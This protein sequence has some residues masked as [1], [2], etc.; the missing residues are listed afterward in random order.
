MGDY[1]LELARTG[2]RDFLRDNRANDFFADDMVWDFSGFRGW[3][4]DTEYHGPHGFD[5]QMAR[6]TAPFD[7]WAMEITEMID[8]GGD[9]VLG[10][11]V[12][13]GHL[14][15]SGAVVEMPIAQIWTIRDGKL[16]RI[17]MFVDA[18]DAYRAAGIEPPSPA[19]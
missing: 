12:Q 19:R 18:P 10:I 17:R 15:G 5:E 16:T 1:K 14:K 6:W 11:G 2:L 9:D 4:E 13:R 3:V 7:D 8:A